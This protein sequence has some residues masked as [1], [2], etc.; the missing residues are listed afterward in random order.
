MAEELLKGKFTEGSSIKIKYQA[1]CDD[2][3]ADV[4]VGGFRQRQPRRFS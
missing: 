2:A 3:V 1:R 4:W